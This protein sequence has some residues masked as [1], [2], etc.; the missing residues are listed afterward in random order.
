MQKSISITY[1]SLLWIIIFVIIT[2]ILLLK[3]PELT[4]Y[5]KGNSNDRINAILGITGNIIGGIIGGIVAYIVAAYQ[6]SK[7]HEQSELNGLKQ[8]YVTLNLLLD[9]ID[10]NEKV[11]KSIPINEALEAKAQHLATQLVSEQ[12]NK[13]PP[14]FADHLDK[15]DFKNICRLYRNISLIKS[16]TNSVSEPFISQSQTLVDKLKNNI[17]Y[18]LNEILLKIK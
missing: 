1:K 2:V 10:F 12:W 17:S 5:L 16:N 11:F 9:E 8:S 14:S 3:I 7:S 13:I 6:V 4:S 18:T 15:E